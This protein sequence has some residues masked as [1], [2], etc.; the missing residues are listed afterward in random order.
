MEADIFLPPQFA[1]PDYS[2]LTATIPPDVGLQRAVQIGHDL[3]EARRKLE[4]DPDNLPL[5]T[6][7]ETLTDELEWAASVNRRKFKIINGGKPTRR[8]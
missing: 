5:K 1:V 6:T 8:S 7:V 4:K 3:H 2:R